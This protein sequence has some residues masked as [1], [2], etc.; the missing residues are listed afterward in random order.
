[1]VDLRMN[2]RSVWWL[3]TLGTL[4]ACNNGDSSSVGTPTPPPAGNSA[5]GK[6]LYTLGYSGEIGAYRVDEASGGL[7]FMPAAS[8]NARDRPA[9]VFSN[10]NASFLYLLKGG[11]LYSNSGTYGTNP[12]LSVLSIDNVEGS[13]SEESGS[14]YPIGNYSPVTKLVFHPSNKFLYAIDRDI[15]GYSINAVTGRLTATSG[16]PYSLD[17]IPGFDGGGAFHSSG[18]YLSVVR[19]GAVD[20]F[21]VN[22]ST[23]ALSL[24]NSVAYDGFNPSQ[25]VLSNAGS[26]LYF[27][28]TTTNGGLEFSRWLAAYAISPAGTLTR[29]S[30]GP[31]SLDTDSGPPV[32]HPSGRYI[33]VDNVAS[34]GLG[35]ITAFSIS[36]MTGLPIPVANS[37][38]STGGSGAGELTITPD[39]RF[40]AVA[41]SGI[42]AN[43]GISIFGIDTGT[44]SLTAATPATLTI[45][46]IYPCA[47]AFHPSGK[48]LYVIDCVNDPRTLHALTLHTATGML[49]RTG[50]YPTGA[51]SLIVPGSL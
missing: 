22:D 32:M 46:G 49:T 18:R 43:R 7:T 15:R 48:S 36:D 31:V 3:L 34:Y 2:A 29:I 9:A 13:L 19:S 1:M 21:S 10:S 30:G 44:G 51:D 20:T 26:F 24:S 5:A 8:F 4:A 6:F 37:P 45:N 12:T 25:P 33:Y 38:F 27:S 23:G 17:P 39:G 35:R 28:Y 47:M 50:N 16:S 42:G 41:H 40:L 11:F 14:P